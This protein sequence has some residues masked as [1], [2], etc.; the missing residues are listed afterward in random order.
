MRCQDCGAELECR[1]AQ[2]L[3]GGRLWWDVESVC[4]ACG[5]L[6]WCA[7]GI[8]RTGDAAGDRGVGEHAAI[9]RVLRRNS[10]STW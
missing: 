8:C 5:F 4:S 7:P 10:A 1:G 3:V 6:S 2:A 9:M